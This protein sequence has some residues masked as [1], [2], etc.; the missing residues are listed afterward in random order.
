MN[1]QQVD[2]PYQRI[3]VALDGSELAEEIFP[4]VIP[5]AHA[6][7]SHVSLIRVVEPVEPPVYAGNMMNHPPQIYYGDLAE[8][9]KQAQSEASAYL[10]SQQERLEHEGLT[11]G[12][13]TPEGPAAQSIL[14]H[15]R[16]AD[17]NLIAMT[18][19][20]RGGLGR[21]VFGSVAEAVLRAA[22]CPVLLVRVQHD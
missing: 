2:N 13:L 5:L 20:G 8:M 1:A 15:A 16:A 18:T 21:L 7:S 6:F 4:V 11:V 9:A 10:S 12:C 3:L 14:N 22:P 17:T 19:H